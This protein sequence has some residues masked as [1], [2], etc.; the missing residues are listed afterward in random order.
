[1]RKA[2]CL[3]LLL[4]GLMLPALAEE[5]AQVP[6]T[7]V[8][9][10][11]YLLSNEGGQISTTGDIPIP[12]IITEDGFLTMGA[13][14]ERYTHPLLLDSTAHRWYIQNPYGPEK[15]YLNLS[16][17]LLLLYDENRST[18]LYFI[19]PDAQP[20]TLSPAKPAASYGGVWRAEWLYLWGNTEDDGFPAKIYFFDLCGGTSTITLPMACDYD[21]IRQTWADAIAQLPAQSA[22]HSLKE[23]YG[24]ELRSPYELLLVTSYGLVSLYRTDTIPLPDPVV[25]NY[26]R[27][28]AND[29]RLVDVTVGGISLPTEAAGSLAS[30][31]TIDKYGFADLDGEVVALQSAEGVI[32]IGDYTI[33]HDDEYLYLSFADGIYARYITEAEWYHRHLPGT[34]QLSRIKAPVIGL[35]QAVSPADM[36]VQLVIQPDDEGFFRTPDGD[37]GFLLSETDDVACY[38]LLADTGDEQ[39]LTI[40]G[41]NQLHIS[42]ESGTYTLYFVPAEA[43]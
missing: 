39:L 13:E 8:G 11:E 27:Y 30:C 35:D 40:A 4:L 22:A 1:M 37:N 14:E 10:W 33:A 6:E 17:N 9:E 31:L 16:R 26:A 15:L 36:N 28:V 5:G 18:I 43:E 42:N 2:L 23:I 12:L 29:W 32:S 38:S 24:Y 3:A 7:F 34:W 25:R 41:P 21:T 19:R 20:V